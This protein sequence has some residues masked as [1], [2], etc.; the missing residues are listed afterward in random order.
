MNVHVSHSSYGVDRIYV[1]GN[2]N[3]SN[4]AHRRTTARGVVACIDII[5]CT[6]NVIYNCILLL[7]LLLFR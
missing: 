3:F 4:L 6:H 5:L 7:L 1:Y 2:N